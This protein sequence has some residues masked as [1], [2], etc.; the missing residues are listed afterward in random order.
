MKQ[1]IIIG[2]GGY[3][4]EAFTQ[5]KQSIGYGKE[6]VVKGY[7]DGNLNALNGFDDYPPVLSTIEAYILEQEDVFIC[8]IGDVTI[9]RKTVNEILKKEGNFIN[10]IHKSCTIGDNVQ[11]GTGLFISYDVIISNDT[12]IENYVL[13]NSRAIVGHDCRVESFSLIGVS[14][15][16]A[17]NVTV[18]EDV[19]IHPSASI[20]QGLTLYDG[21]KVGLGSVVVKDVKEDSTVFGNPAKVIF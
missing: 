2:A 3:G 16:L 12:T 17:G 8:A 7:L 20:M 9:R 1:L 10:L 4:R 11:L 14:T 13:I 15:F 21:A 6:F 19:T 5:A 18:M